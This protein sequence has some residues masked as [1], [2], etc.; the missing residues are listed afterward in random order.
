MGKTSYLMLSKTKGRTMKKSCRN[1]SPKEAIPQSEADVPTVEAVE[2][3]AHNLTPSSFYRSE[4]FH[5]R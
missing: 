1:I 5:S 4:A 2:R 3:V